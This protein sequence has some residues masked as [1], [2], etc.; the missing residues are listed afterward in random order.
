MN[1]YDHLQDGRRSSTAHAAGWV[2]SI[3]AQELVCQAAGDAEH[4]SA[5]VLALDVQL[6]E[7][8]LRVIVPNPAD[9]GNVAGLSI[10]LLGT[11]E[12][13]VAGLDHAGG[14]HDLQPASDW[15]SQQGVEEASRSSQALLGRDASTSLDGDHVQEAEHSSAAVL[16]LHD[17]VAA[18]VTGLDQAERVEHA[19]RR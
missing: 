3:D 19:Q 8:G 9:V 13:E 6:E 11:C 12:W 5:A 4:C 17:L 14:E 15:D 10:V 16:D 7:L 18:H 2:E 1:K